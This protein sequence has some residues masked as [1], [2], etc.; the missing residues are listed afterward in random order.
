MYRNTLRGTLLYLLNFSKI[1]AKRR[2][3]RTYTLT[4][5]DLLSIYIKQKGRCA[6]TNI[7]LAFTGFYQM[8]LDRINTNKGYEQGNVSLII[9][10]L[11]TGDW[12][13]LKS[14]HDDRE[15][16]AGWNREKILWAVRQNTRPIIPQISYLK[17]VYDN[18][19]PVH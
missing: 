11:N 2:R 9:Q 18:S 17:N 3:N 14:K 6:Y 7:P 12:S 5:D 10:S 13:V 8:S 1:H 19:T 4:F 16:S 15:G